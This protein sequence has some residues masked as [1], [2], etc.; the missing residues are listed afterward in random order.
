MSKKSVMAKIIGAGIAVVMAMSFLMAAVPGYNIK[1]YAAENLL[2]NPGAETGDI[3][4]WWE[5]HTYEYDCWRAV[6]ESSNA[7]EVTTPHSGKYQFMGDKRGIPNDRYTLLCQ[8]VDASDFKV[9]DKFELSAYCHTYSDDTDYA[10]DYGE[11]YLEFLDKDKA[12]IYPDGKTAAVYT[13]QFNGAN[14]DKVSVQGVM[15][16]GTGVILVGICGFNI[17]GGVYPNVSFDDV[18]LVNLGQ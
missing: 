9:G 6:T 2:V 7:G 10:P 16:E 11:I 18:S 17:D 5:S 13:A 1:A 3:T 8:W 12:F 4:G 15:P 14:W